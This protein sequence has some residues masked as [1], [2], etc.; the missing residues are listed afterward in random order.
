MLAS[1][2][3]TV[4]DPGMTKDFLASAAGIYIVLFPFR[5]LGCTLVERWFT[6]HRFVLRKVIALDLATTLFLVLVTLPLANKVI[7]LLGVHAAVPD[8]IQSLPLAARV[9][10]YLVLADFGHYWIHRLM[11]HR[12]LWSIH[13]WHHSPTHMSWAAGNRESLIDAILVNSAYAFF[14]PILGPVPAWLGALLLVFAIL[15]NDW[16]HLN[17]RWSLPWLESLVVTPRYHHIHHSAEPAHFNSNFAIVFSIWDRLF[18]TYQPPRVEQDSLRFGTG[19]R[20]PLVRL[21]TGL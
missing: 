14:W 1:R 5:L 18:G 9:V 15:K 16:M 6:A 21:V 2:N 20:T 10:L 7:S 11:H 4:Q 3:R 8:I 17:V 13:K 12:F 19:E